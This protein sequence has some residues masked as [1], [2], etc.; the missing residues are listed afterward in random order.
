M[1]IGY[2]LF[3]RKRN[4]VKDLSRYLFYPID[5]SKT[6]QRLTYGVEFHVIHLKVINLYKSI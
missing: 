6:I 1:T 5:Q 3:I 4:I 2:D